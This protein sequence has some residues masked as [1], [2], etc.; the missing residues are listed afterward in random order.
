VRSA[1]LLVVAGVAS[2]VGKTTVTLGLLDAFRRRGLT[3]QGFKVGPDFID[4]GFQEIVTGRGSYNL[5]GWMCG[6]DHV[7][8][9]VA[10]HTRDVDVAVV[11]GVMG[12]F[13][14]LEATSDEGSTAQVAKWLDAPVVLVID[15]HAQARSAAAV[16]LGFE[17]L[18]PDLKL[19]AVIAN[20]VGG[21]AHA[22]AIRD[23]VSACC[24]AQ[25]VGALPH[26]AQV[27]LAERHLGLVTAGEGGLTEDKRGRLA[28][29]IERGVD[30]DRLLELAGPAPTSM[31][32][33][34]PAPPTSTVRIGVA[35]DAAFC[36]YYRDN[37]ARLRAA[38]AELVYWSPLAD[39]GL[40][41]VDGLYLGGGYPELH[42]AALAGNKTM[43]QAVLAFAEA[44]R[45][46]YAECG[47]LMYLAEALEDLDGVRHAMV[48]L[49]PAA[50]RMRPRRLS[51]SYTEVTL[52]AASPLGPPGTVA[53]GHEFHFSTLDP[54]R[55]SVARAYRLRRRGGEDGEEGYRIRN[56]LLSYVHLH[57]GSN[58]D[59]AAGFVHA[60]A[61][62]RRG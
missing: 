36:F 52:Q 26:D 39:G 6:R 51:L 5:D 43:R 40:P 25:L 48:G 34:E 44:G 22:R 8:A 53:R 62:A 12:C 59:L 60:C 2:G 27:A 17:Q 14:G 20:R 33:A 31:E 61:E 38:G 50:V 54:V 7:L 21:S 18:D 41:A 1:R 32:R 58:P 57:F 46:V 42:G 23:A 55:A 10:R 29:A 19:A 3:V 4:S 30:L 11:E 45:P 35:H 49:L 24:R 9:T 15:V 56:A 37:L 47:G 13:D 28:D 16:V